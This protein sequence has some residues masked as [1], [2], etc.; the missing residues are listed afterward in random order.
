MITIQNQPFSA[1]IT[2]SHTSNREGALALKANMT[3]FFEQPN[4]VTPYIVTLTERGYQRIGTTNR[5]T[6]EKIFVHSIPSA[7]SMKQSEAR[8]IQQR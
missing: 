8:D 2:D 6:I 1:L 5:D 3:A 7:S 4:P